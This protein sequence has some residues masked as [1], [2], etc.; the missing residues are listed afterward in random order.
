MVYNGCCETTHDSR[1]DSTRPSLG[2]RGRADR[3]RHTRH[4]LWGAVLALSPSAPFSG[5]V[6]L[7]GRQEVR[8]L[9]LPGPW[10]RRESDHGPLGGLHEKARHRVPA[11]SPVV[12]PYHHRFQI[13]RERGPSVLEPLCPDT[14]RPVCPLLLVVVAAGAR[15]EGPDL[16]HS[17]PTRHARV[18]LSLPLPV[19]PA[20]AAAAAARRSEP[21]S[22]P[23]GVRRRLGGAVDRT[24][25]RITQIVCC[26]HP[27]YHHHRSP[28]QTYATRASFSSAPKSSPLFPLGG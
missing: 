5:L 17:H 13:Q 4:G 14:H 1:R 9:P 8:N 19:L 16:K 10:T 23:Q 20:C 7:S 11:V 26:P 24:P 6:C 27:A 22:R 18:S 12:L 2:E 21:A 25:D 3:H 28:R 15:E